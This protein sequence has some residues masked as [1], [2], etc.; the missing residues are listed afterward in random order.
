MKKICPNCEKESTEWN[1]DAT[2]SDGLQV[3]CRECTKQRDREYYHSNKNNRKKKIRE[4]VKHE[5]DRIDQLIQDAKKVGCKFCPEKEIVCMDF[6][7]LSDKD[8]AIGDFKK[9][10]YS[11]VKVVKEIEKCIVVCSNCH[12][13][14]H[15]GLL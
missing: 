14:I 6:H 5:R 15:A 3:Y 12:R 11:F 1:K 4:R 2:R 7:H 8:F 10:S 9:H 13:K